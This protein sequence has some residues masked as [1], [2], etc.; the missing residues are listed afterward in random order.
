VQLTGSILKPFEKSIHDG[1]KTQARAKLA[2]F[3][4]LKSIGIT[5]SFGKTSVKFILQEILSQKLSV[6][7]TPSSFNTPMGISRVVNND[8][9]SKH[10]VFIAEMGARYEG[11][12]AELVDLVHPEIGVVTSVGPAHLET[13]GPVEKIARVKGELIRGLPDSGLAVLNMD[14]PFVRDMA[15]ST[16]ARGLYVSTKKPEADFL[17]SNISYDSTGSRFSVSNTKQGTNY[18]FQSQLLGEHNIL[19]ILFGI[20][21]ASH[22]GIQLRQMSHAVSRIK[23][24][25]H[26]LALREQAGLF[27]I[28]DAFNSNPVGSKNAI[29]YNRDF[30]AYMAGKVDVVILVGQKQTAPIRQGLNESGFPNENLH[31]V[32]SLFDAQD[33]LPSLSQ[34]GDIVLYENDLP[35]QYSE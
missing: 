23:A 4:D 34:D 33:L 25:P 14:D 29:K 8:L 7:A 27:V 26:R 35:D 10:Q 32:N 28:D 19:N 9:Q 15:G 31:I 12:I 22:F 1:F 11:D 20:G 30:G 16:K 24:I 13:M 3:S 5:G 18:D 21:I 6:L 2:S 17:A